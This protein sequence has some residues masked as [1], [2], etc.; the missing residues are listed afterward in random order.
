MSEMTKKA[1][2]YKIISIEIINENR[3]GRC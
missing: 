3:R 2:N 1:P